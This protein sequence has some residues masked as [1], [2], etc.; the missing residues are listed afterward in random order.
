MCYREG[1]DEFS[2]SSF[3]NVLRLVIFLNRFKN[4]FVCIILGLS[5]IININEPVD[6]YNKYG[7]YTKIYITKFDV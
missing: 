6:Y 3:L 1:F 4:D 2:G 7:I 5:P